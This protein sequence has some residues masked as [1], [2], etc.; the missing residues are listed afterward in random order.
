MLLR[1]KSIVMN[2]KKVLRMM[3]KYGLLAKIRK[4]NPYKQIMKVTQEHRTT[5]NK[6]N[7]EF[8]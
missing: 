3:K 6:L 1:N 2:H 4:P 8:G 7:R 5:G